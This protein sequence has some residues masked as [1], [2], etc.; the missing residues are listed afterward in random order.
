MIEGKDDM[1]T[2]QALNHKRA[3][4]EAE[5]QAWN[6]ARKQETADNDD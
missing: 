1:V 2:F 6:E 3:E 4:K 5:F